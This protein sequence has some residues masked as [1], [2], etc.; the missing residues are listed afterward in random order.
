MTA[1]LVRSFSDP[2]SGPQAAPRLL[3]ARDSEAAQRRALSVVAR[4]ARRLR[5][6]VVGAS[7]TAGPDDAKRLA[8]RIGLLAALTLVG[9][10]TPVTGEGCRQA[11]IASCVRGGDLTCPYPGQIMTR[12]P[13]EDCKTYV[14]TCPR[15]AD[16]GA[17]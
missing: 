9:C 4:S 5:G 14:C 17:Q 16:G 8:H 6:F 3:R 7:R 13:E 15:S 2:H 12:V 1:S 10:N 11:V